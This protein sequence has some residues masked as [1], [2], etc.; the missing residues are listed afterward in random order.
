MQW[1]KTRAQCFL[2]LH[3]RPVPE[4]LPF[5]GPIQNDIIS[6]QAGLQREAELAGVRDRQ[7][8]GVFEVQ[9]TRIGES[10]TGRQELDGKGHGGDSREESSKLSYHR[11]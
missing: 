9:R 11:R 4:G 5:G 3:L 7:Q 10:Q 1:R 2:Q 8:I 6:V